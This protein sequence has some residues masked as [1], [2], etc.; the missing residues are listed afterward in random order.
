MFGIIPYLG[1]GIVLKH[2]TNGM[3]DLQSIAHLPC[4]YCDLRSR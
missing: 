1:T 3:K 4:D 2:T